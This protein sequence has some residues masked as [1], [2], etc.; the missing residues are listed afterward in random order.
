M[1]DW[2]KVW[3]YDLRNPKNEEYV[4]DM[5]KRLKLEK[6]VCECFGNRDMVIKMKLNFEKKLSTLSAKYKELKEVFFY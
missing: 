4:K 1:K 6:N 3:Y 5:N 2:A